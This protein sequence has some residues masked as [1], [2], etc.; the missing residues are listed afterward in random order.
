VIEEDDSIMEFAVPAGDVGRLDAWL[1]AQCEGFSRSRI[2]GLIKAGRMT[3][4]GKECSRGTEKVKEGDIVALS[5][6]PPVP[7]IPEPED[8]ALDVVFEDADIIVVNKPAGLVVH[9]APGHLDGTLVNALLHHCPDLAGIGGVARP[10]IVHRL[11]QDTSGLMIVAKSER[12]MQTLT[13]EFASHEQ[14]EKIYIALVHG[15]PNPLQGRIET[16]IGRSPYD[17]K[18]MAIVEKNGKIAVT[19]YKTLPVAAPPLAAVECLIETG[20]THQIRVH[21][22]SIGCPIAGDRVYGRQSSD[23]KL[24]TFPARQM[25]H[26][27]KLNLKHPVTREPL[28]FVAPIPEDFKP[29][30]TQHVSV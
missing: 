2:Q 14:I 6:P 1:A 11:D 25:L 16:L 13:K 4:N 17:R 30:L 12:A 23:K 26:A 8:I 5:I 24:E 3:V 15:K 9:P 28:R 27:H 20:R 19:N 21:L 7:A 18:K 22:S 29:Y 10:G